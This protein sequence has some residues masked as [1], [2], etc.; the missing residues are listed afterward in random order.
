M[1]IVNQGILK[2]WQ[3]IC[4]L[5]LVYRVTHGLQCRPLNTALC[6]PTTGP[7][8]GI[9]NGNCCDI[10]PTPFSASCIPRITFMDILFLM[11][12]LHSLEL[13]SLEAV[14]GK[15]ICIYVYFICIPFWNLILKTDR[16]LLLLA[17]YHTVISHAYRGLV[18]KVLSSETFFRTKG[19]S[20]NRTKINAEK[21]TEG[22]TGAG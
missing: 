22:K 5:G 17:D 21:Q 13:L 8:L 4:W 15:F 12:A 1:V 2:I 11:G 14:I 16:K 20:Q 9:R 18:T 7:T 19:R 6:Y 10:V 3:N